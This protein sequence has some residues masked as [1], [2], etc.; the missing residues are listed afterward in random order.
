MPGPAQAKRSA[1]VTPWQPENPPLLKGKSR[2]RADYPGGDRA[3]TE[4]LLTLEPD[5]GAFK[6]SVLFE[7]MRGVE[8]SRM[9]GYSPLP[10]DA[11]RGKSLSTNN[12][13]KHYESLIKQYNRLLRPV[14]MADLRKPQLTLQG[15]GYAQRIALPDSAPGQKRRGFAQ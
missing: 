12:G 7:K 2:P 10:Q 14:K 3:T 6:E 5:G 9:T 13:L 15:A 8:S 11:W 4:S 1:Q